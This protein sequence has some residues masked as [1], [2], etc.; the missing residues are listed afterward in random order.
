[1][2][3][4]R[5]GGQKSP[6]RRNAAPAPAARYYEIAEW[7]NHVCVTV[8]NFEAVC[9]RMHGHAARMRRKTDTRNGAKHQIWKWTSEQGLQNFLSLILPCPHTYR[10]P[11]TLIYVYMCK[12]KET[13]V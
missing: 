8:C 11:S 2:I 1:M 9:V 3:D 13:Y 5:K 10:Y 12:A 7:S 4:Q 6:G